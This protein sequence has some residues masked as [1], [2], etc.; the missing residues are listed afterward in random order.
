MH[1]YRGATLPSNI[2]T[3]TTPLIAK[4]PFTVLCLQIISPSEAIEMFHLQKERYIFFFL[5]I[6][7]NGFN[8]ICLI[9]PTSSIF[10]IF[11]YYYV[12]YNTKYEH[13]YQLKLD[14]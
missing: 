5:S 8:C 3:Y 7:A 9:L 12:Y 14:H 11:K 10:P 13:D 4:L 1:Y 2:T 6:N